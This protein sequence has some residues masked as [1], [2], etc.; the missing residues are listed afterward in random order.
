MSWGHL[1]NVA[2]INPINIKGNRYASGIIRV[3]KSVIEIWI[4]H[5]VAS[6]SRITKNM[7]EIMFSPL[8]FESDL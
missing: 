1:K 7:L 5:H 2:N 3:R 6:A 8:P 4:A